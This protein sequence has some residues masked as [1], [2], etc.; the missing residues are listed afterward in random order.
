M[1]TK[2][3]PQST[4]DIC[5]EEIGSSKVSDNIRS[6]ASMVIY[7]R[8]DTIGVCHQARSLTNGFEVLNMN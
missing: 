1:F 5:L 8:I 6:G 3:L 4:L 7:E 2:T